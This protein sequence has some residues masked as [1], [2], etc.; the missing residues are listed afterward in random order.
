MRTLSPGAGI[1]GTDG[2]RFLQ[3]T[4]GGGCLSVPGMPDSGARVLIC[5]VYTI[6]MRCAREACIMS[7]WDPV[8]V[9][10]ICKNVSL[11][12]N[13]CNNLLTFILLF[14]LMAAS[15]INASF[16]GS[17]PNHY[18]FV[19]VLLM[20]AL[21]VIVLLMRMWCEILGK[22]N[23]YYGNMLHRCEVMPT[24]HS[25]LIHIWRQN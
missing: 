4:V 25:P 5:V 9:I 24:V 13:T 3:N 2:D 12:S 23:Y 7:G 11:F 19:L 10:T 20:H 18:T 22:I 16:F 15:P 14:I 8:V 21:R 1:L 17:H 6:W